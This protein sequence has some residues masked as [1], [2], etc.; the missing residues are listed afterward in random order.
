MNL[1]S[2]ELLQNALQNLGH[3]YQQNRLMD[4]ENA[5]RQQ[6]L[7]AELERTR[8]DAAFRQAQ[9]QHFQNQEDQQTAAAT[10]QQSRLDAIEKKY[11]MQKAY[12]DLANAK[13]TIAGG[14][15]GLAMDTNLSPADKTSYFQKSIQSLP[16][17]IRQGVLQ[18]AHVQAL[19]D[20]KADWNA[21]GTALKPQSYPGGATE[22]LLDKWHQAQAAADHENDPEAKSQKQELAD[23]YK[24]NLPSELK[25]KQSTINKK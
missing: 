24:A 17:D 20:G 15:R 2:A 12:Q 21:L 11:G 19:Y 23:M 22:S 1:A 16:D 7:A 9:L 8:A 25:E 10:A 5:F 6:Q 14:M 4:A 13:E 18:N 3:T